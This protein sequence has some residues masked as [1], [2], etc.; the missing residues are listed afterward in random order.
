MFFPPR[1]GDKSRLAVPLWRSSG[2]RCGPIVMVMF[3]Y[4]HFHKVM[5]SVVETLDAHTHPRELVT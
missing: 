5:R 2:L 4:C 1:H 3:K